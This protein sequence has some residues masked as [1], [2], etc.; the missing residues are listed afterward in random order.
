MTSR[1]VVVG[2][3]VDLVTWRSFKRNQGDRADAPE[4]GVPVSAQLE[5]KE[6]R[7][8]GDSRGWV[9]PPVSGRFWRGSWREG[10]DGG[11]EGR[12]VF[13][14]DGTLVVRE[15]DAD[16]ARLH[17]S[18]LGGDGD[19]EPE[20]RERQPWKAV[21]E[22]DFGWF[23]ALMD[24]A[25]RRRRH[26]REDVGRRHPRRVRGDQRR[27]L[28]GAGGR[29]PAQRAASDPRS[30]L[31][32]VWL[33]A[34]GRAARL[35]GGQRLHELHR[36]RRRSRLHAADQP[37]HVRHPPRAGHRQQQPFAYT[38]DEHG[39]TITHK[40]EA[41]YLDDG[42]EKPVR[43]WSRTGRRPLLAAGNS[44]GDIGMLEFTPHP[45][46]RPCGCSFSTTTPS[47]SST[48]RLAPRRRS[49]APPPTA[50]PSSA[51]R[52]TGPRL[53]TV[54]ASDRRARGTPAQLGPHSALIPRPHGSGSATRASASPRPRARGRRTARR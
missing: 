2:T 17:P 14:N 23:G 30:R 39:G 44:N 1:V 22:R 27:R 53:L 19:G 9:V 46:S 13:D 37:G 4:H 50:G 45:T 16:P 8:A 5:G 33:R 20:L 35:P 49:S 38:S 12:A 42:P 25:L 21:S 48:T 41:D 47:A 40:P 54:G 32:R 34:D 24:R 15:A 10:G 31:P 18:P 11:G 26:Q 3:G 7:S 52:T 6:D 28:R 43:I 36:L 29:L 51:S